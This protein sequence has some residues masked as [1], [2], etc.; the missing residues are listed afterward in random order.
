MGGTFVWVNK[1]YVVEIYNVKMQFFVHILC[2][3]HFVC[4]LEADLYSSGG[5]WCT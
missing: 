3:V 5:D 2:G 4:V 1:G